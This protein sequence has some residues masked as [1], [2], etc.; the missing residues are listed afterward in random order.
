MTLKSILTSIYA[1]V[2]PIICAA[3]NPTINCPEDITLTAISGACSAIGTYTV[4]SDNT[5]PNE[6]IFLID[7]IGS[8]GSFPVGVTTNTW[9][10][11]DEIGNADTCSFNIIVQEIDAPFIICPTPISAE[12]SPGE[13]GGFVEY[14]IQ[15]V[16]NCGFDSI[17]IIAGIPSGG[18][19]PLGYTINEFVAVNSIGLTDTCRFDV[20]VA[21]VENPMPNCPPD[22]TVDADPNTCLAQ[23]TY[24]LP[25]FEDNCGV[26]TVFQIAGLASNSFFP[27]GTT[28]NT[29]S[30]LDEAGN[31]GICSFSIIVEDGSNPG[32]VSCP[33]DITVGTDQDSCGAFVNYEIP[34]VSGI[35][36]EIDISLRQNLSNTVDGSF[37]CGLNKESRHLRVFDLAGMGVVGDFHIETISIGIGFADTNDQ[38]IDLNIYELDGALLY[39]NMTLVFSKQF[40][41]PTLGNMNYELFTNYDIERNKI[42]VIELVVPETN[43]LQFIAGYSLETE[44][45][46]SYFSSVECGW[47][48]PTLTSVV[49]QNLSLIMELNGTVSN[50]ITPTQTEG[51]ERGGYFPL[52]TTSNVY[53]LPDGSSCSFDVTVEDQTNPSIS[54]PD[55][56]SINISGPVCDTFVMVPDP[57]VSDLCG[58]VS[59]INDFNNTNSAQDIYSNGLTSVTWTATDEA[60]NSA[61]CLIAVE[62]VGS[63]GV[64]ISS[65]NVTCHGGNDGSIDLSIN[66]GN[67]PPYTFDWTGGLSGQ[68]PSMLSAGTY[69]LTVTDNSNCVFEAEIVIEEPEQFSLDNLLITDATNGNPNG[70]INVVIIGGTPPYVYNWSTGDTEP[71]VS[72]LG[73]GSYTCTVVDANGCEFEL[74][75]F[76]VDDVV[77]VSKADLFETL[78][79]Y[80]NPSQG[81]LNITFESLEEEIKSLEIFSVQGRKIIERNLDTKKANIQ[82]DLS[83]W[84]PGIYFVRFSTKGQVYTHK[85][86][87]D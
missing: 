67:S 60:G 19:F 45:Y 8:G 40:V 1:I 50:N 51:I 33:E 73:M 18:L 35:C 11:I 24:T 56:I 4:T 58:D 80:P 49:G 32:F 81:I 82:M 10:V 31:E 2:L 74:G 78:K 68:N 38:Q 9:V 70:N 71:N 15:T 16:N 7:G 12:S 26:D 59:F 21:D 53:T 44:I 55:E 39:E 65:Q 17:Y 75:P 87:L 29:F 52:G 48:E 83:E 27:V 20:F 30:I 5:C 25:Q 28:V 22:I 76:D 66:S 85:L 46:P 42:I 3:S 69:Q 57:I 41:L 13:C 72:N 63:L 84:H 6:T 54:C 43:T 64:E 34:E 79:I 86:L 47:P 37:G 61:T 77:A 23:V 36:N 62:V 14:E